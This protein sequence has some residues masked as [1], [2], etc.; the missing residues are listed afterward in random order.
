M[1]GGCTGVLPERR[2]PLAATSASFSA[3]DSQNCGGCGNA[4]PA[5]SACQ[6]ARLHADL[7]ARP[8]PLRRTRAPP[9]RT[10]G[11]APRTAAPATTSAPPVQ[12]CLD[13]HCSRDLHGRLARFA[14]RRPRTPTARTK[15]HRREQL[16][17]LRHRLRPRRLVRRRL[18]GLPERRHRLRAE[19]R[20]LRDRPLRRRCAL[21]Q[22]E[23]GPEQ[24]LG[25]RQ[26]LHAAEPLLFGRSLLRELH[27]AR[28]NSLRRHLRRHLGRRQKLRRLREP[29]P[30][31]ATAL[32][33]RPRT[34]A[35]AVCPPGSSS[36]VSPGSARGA[37]RP[38]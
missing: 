30:A 17:K 32:C 26:P 33:S 34:P 29:C 21:R 31:G 19:R 37:G 6:D 7:P 15:S 11:K 18:C 9:A 2:S 25:L 13:G 12:V 4:C 3:N 24:L 27:A 10:S 35:R 16:R 8:D 22:S 14:A 5:G 38:R 28:G 1:D 20:R 36:A 23:R